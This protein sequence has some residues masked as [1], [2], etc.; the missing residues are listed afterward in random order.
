M[1]SVSNSRSS[2][3]ISS[4]VTDPMGTARFHTVSKSGTRAWLSR[5]SL[6]TRAVAVGSAA[7]VGGS[8]VMRR[9]TVI[10]LVGRSVPTR[11]WTPCSDSS[12]SP[13]ARPGKL[14]P[15]RS[16]TTRTRAP[17]RTG[18]PTSSGAGMPSGWLEA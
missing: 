16:T 3:V 10:S 5:E 17:R 14:S 11:I 13:R 7:S 1:S 4:S 8:S 15:S 9:S 2:S 12:L 18:A 6:T